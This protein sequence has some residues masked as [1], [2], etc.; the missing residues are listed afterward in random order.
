MTVKLCNTKQQYLAETLPS[1][2]RA[3]QALGDEK[4]YRDYLM[5]CL[6]A[7]SSAPLVLALAEALRDA[8]G[9]EEASRF[10]S[11]ELARQPSLRGLERLIR[12]QLVNL[13]T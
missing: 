9:D 11:R 4:A 13:R 12:L 3:Y 6:E 1:L 5:Q 8:G 2:R 7:E 10:L